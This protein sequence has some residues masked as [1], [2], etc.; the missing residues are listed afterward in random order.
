[1]SNWR[2]LLWDQGLI[3]LVAGIVLFTNL[4]GPRLW[5]RD[6]PRNAGCAKEMQARGDWVVPVFNNELRDAKPVLLYWF[7][8]SAYWMF[9]MGEFAAR[10]WSV[11]FA[12]GTVLATYH[13][14]RRLWNPSIALWSAL[15]LT[16]TLM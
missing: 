16:T 9:G 3:V 2:A 13:L 4:G 8:M 14:G 15:I 6:E 1:M 11:I 5:D 12:I 10:F 7:I